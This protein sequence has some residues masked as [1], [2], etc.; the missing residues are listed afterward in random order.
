MGCFPSRLPEQHHPCILVGSLVY[1]KP[2]PE[3]NRRVIAFRIDTGEV[4]EGSVPAVQA[5]KGTIKGI[6][7]LGRVQ[8]PEEE[9]LCVVQEWLQ[10]AMKEA[11]Q[12]LSE[13]LIFEA[14][15]AACIANRTQPTDIDTKVEMEIF[16]GYIVNRL[17]NRPFVYK[18]PSSFP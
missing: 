4:E 13:G 8:V 6:G 17:R 3:F 18:R 9:Q 10:T 5:G 1:G 15:R 16:R 11:G 14:V 2:V 7:I 12:N